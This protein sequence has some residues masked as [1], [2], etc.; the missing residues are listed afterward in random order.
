[1]TMTFSPDVPDND[2]ASALME[3]GLTFLNKA[4]SELESDP[5]FSL[6]NF[7]NGV[8]I[9]MKVPLVN[10]DWRLI[11]GRTK[12]KQAI[13]REEFLSGDFRSVGF[14]ETCKLLKSELGICID[15]K[16]RLFFE[17]VQKH[18]NRMVHFY[19]AAV[20]DADLDALRNEQADAWF[21]LSRLITQE[22]RKAFHTE[23]WSD[24]N[25]I[26]IALLNSSKYYAGAKFRSVREQL[27][28]S[29][30]H[31]RVCKVCSQ[32]AYLVIKDVHT[33]VFTEDCKVCS[34]FEH[35]LLVRCPECLHES[36]LEE[37]DEAFRCNNCNHS[38]DR[39]LAL[40][41]SDPLPD[42]YPNLSTPAG[43]CE[44]EGYDTVCQYG[45]GYLCT[46]CLTYYDSIEWCACC[47]Y[48]SSSV[49]DQSSM[50]GCGFC[51]G[52]PETWDLRD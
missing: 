38:L 12:G 46:Q 2:D 22:W 31:Y 23:Q 34:Q 39:F 28:E 47:S 52:H 40:D 13:S 10:C 9:L 44:C 43:C 19:H 6:I 29:P 20:A 18:R 36:K 32:A 35:Y 33:P 16:T 3:N 8:E 11:V 26:N 14:A 4:I 49:P 1:M 42:E 50:V 25:N 15:D 37:G 5:K 21:A 24:V 30:H 7:W 45:E 27:E 48:P 51:D 41:E 17:T